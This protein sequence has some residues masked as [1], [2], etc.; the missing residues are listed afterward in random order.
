MANKELNSNKKDSHDFEIVNVKGVIFDEQ[1]NFRGIVIEKK[2]NTKSIKILTDK[3]QL[4][5][6]NITREDVF[7]I[8]I[9][10]GHAIEFC[11]KN[12]IYIGDISY[13]NILF[14]KDTKAVYIIDIDS[15]SLK[16]NQNTVFTDSF[17]DPL[18]INKNGY[19][20]TS[21][22]ADWYAYSILCFYLLTL[23][24]P[25]NG[26][27]F[28]ENGK[29]IQMAMPLRK[30]KKI[31]V[32]GEHNVKIPSIALPWDE[33][34]T[35]SLKNAFLDIFENEKRY[36]I[37]EYI[38]D[39]YKKLFC[40]NKEQA[41][42]IK[43]KK[44]DA[45]Q[46]SLD[47]KEASAENKRENSLNL[48]TSLLV[49]RNKADELLITKDV[50]ITEDTLFNGSNIFAFDYPIKK[51]YVCNKKMIYVVDQNNELYFCYKDIK[52]QMT[53]IDV[54]NNMDLLAIPYSNEILVVNS[55]NELLSIKVENG[56]KKQDSFYEFN[57]SLPEFTLSINSIH[58][59][60]NT[61]KISHYFLETL[62]F[63]TNQGDLD[64]VHICIDLVM[65]K[66]LIISDD[67]NKVYVFDPKTA[68]VEQVNII[69][70]KLH[71]TTIQNIIFFNNAIYYPVDGKISSLNV[72]NLNYLEFEC[73][74][75]TNT[76]KIEIIKNGFRI[77]NF[78][79][80]YDLIKS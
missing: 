24:H 75:V 68:K 33:F 5:K 65:D 41:D 51:V 21:F 72:F 77:S 48:D 73:D 50:R 30:S 18:A 14:D 16:Q 47:D 10:I 67:F 11:H 76:S 56:V 2:E 20:Q 7:K 66:W 80:V 39:N 31:S 23:L 6:Y 13:N 71:D 35:D 79:A 53:N 38:E 1:R 59:E 17:V 44:E 49:K 57:D 8:L 3:L 63:L 45:I 40:K 9:S 54:K 27:Y 52:E 46:Y 28:D 60:N 12:G 70:E 36:N 37:T 58:G 19:A 34:M 78:D 15:V 74:K 22:E 32:L 69:C 62:K 43:D 26:T 55:N 25:F 4:S 61:E 64:K 42:K 29:R